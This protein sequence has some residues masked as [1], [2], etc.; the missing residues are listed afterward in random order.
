MPTFLP[1]GDGKVE[2]PILALLANGSSG[3]WSVTLDES[4]E[5]TEDRFLQIEG[6]S[7]NLYCQVNNPDILPRLA[8]FL[9]AKTK[10]QTVLVI[11]KV[12]RTTL[13]LHSDPE[14]VQTFYFSV[15]PASRPLVRYWING[16]DLQNL[17]DARQQASL[18]LE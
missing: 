8:T 14:D 17:K 1:K 18:D 13:R 10:K 5:R 9:K 11:G 4:T 6:P 7:L 15:G 12:D 3:R 16:P 2:S